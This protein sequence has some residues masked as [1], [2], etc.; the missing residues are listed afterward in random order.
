MSPFAVM[1]I[2]VDAAALVLVAAVLATRS[3]HAALA[4][5]PL[6]TAQ[7]VV[8]V[9][10]AIAASTALESL[11]SFAEWT[12]MAAVNL[13]YALTCWRGGAAARL[14]GYTAIGFTTL[15]VVLIV[16]RAFSG[17]IAMAIGLVFAV[18]ALLAALLQVRQTRVPA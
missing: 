1:W 8:I 2:A 17:I 14:L 11:R 15:A 18:G 6:L 12:L 9:A 7:G 13:G 10:S 4:L 3:E 5:R 16:L